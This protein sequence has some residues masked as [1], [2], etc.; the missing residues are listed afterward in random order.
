MTRKNKVL[1][2]EFL[3]TLEDGGT[4]YVKFK[5]HYRRNKVSAFFAIKD[6][7]N[8]AT[9]EFYISGAKD[10]TNVRAKVAI[11]K[12]AVVEFEQAYLAALDKHEARLKARKAKRE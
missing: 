12:K 2:R 3:N 5:V 9:L 6:C 10:T 4:A 7:V 11:L 1:F 8:E